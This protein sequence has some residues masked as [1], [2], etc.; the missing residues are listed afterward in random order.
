MSLVANIETHTLI[1]PA[2]WRICPT[3]WKKAYISSGPWRL[4]SNYSGHICSILNFYSTCW[5]LS[6]KVVVN[7][8]EEF[9]SNCKGVNP[10]LELLRNKVNIFF[11]LRGIS[12]LWEILN[13][14]KMKISLSTANI[15]TLLKFYGQSRDLI[16]LVEIDVLQKGTCLFTPEN[17]PSQISVYMFE[18]ERIS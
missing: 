8:K 7:F 11:W 5:L 3:E 18:S 1:Y 2:L 17:A 12:L 16:S 10:V 14:L 15:A 13:V 9:R 6:Y 4:F